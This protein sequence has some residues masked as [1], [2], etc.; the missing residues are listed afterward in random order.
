MHVINNP[1][2]LGSGCNACHDCV[3]LPATNA[4]TI[5]NHPN[6]F[7]AAETGSVCDSLEAVQSLTVPS[8]TLNVYPNPIVD[9]ND[10]T[11]TYNVSSTQGILTIFNIEGN[12][13]AH[14]SLPQWSSAQH[15]TL[16]EISSG[17]YLARL[18]QGSNG[19]EC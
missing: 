19:G 1:D 4:W 16:P 17:L 7:L 3:I 15:L 6:Y 14:Y 18:T 11:F 2:V 10:V 8:S 9:D 13:V 5:A 12:E